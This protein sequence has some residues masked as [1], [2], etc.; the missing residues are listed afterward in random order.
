MEKKKKK[1]VKLIPN[2][3]MYMLARIGAGAV[4][5]FLYKRKFMRNEIKNIKGP[6]IILA[7]HESALDFVNLINATRAK[8]NFVVSNS[9]YNTLPIREAMR[10]AGVIPK[11]QFQTNMHDIGRMREVIRNNGILVMYPAGLMC[12]D[13]IS[14][15]IPEPTYRFVQWLAADVYIARSYGTYFCKPKWA[16]KTRPGRTYI[17]IYKLC[18]KD[19]LV[20]MSADDFRLMCESA[21]LF[22][23]YREQEELLVKYKGGDNL[24]GLENILYVCPCCRS[25][26]KIVTEGNT[27]RCV[28]CGYEEYSDE[29]GFLHKRSGCGAEMRYVSDWNGFAVTVMSEKINTGAFQGLYSKAKIY[30]IDY[31]KKK[32]VESGEGE[33]TLK[34][35]ALRLVGVVKGEPVDITTPASHFPSLP[36]KPGVNIDF[37]HGGEIYRLELEDGRLCMEFINAIK[38][39]YQMSIPVERARESERHDEALSVNV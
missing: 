38:Y 19:E 11:N 26:H 7:N 35:A 18:N 31:K 36:F 24:E 22:D 8:M 2:K 6:A 5:K 9:F 34:D 32:Y 17:D 1:K 33:L 10:G 4:S 30:T 27:I 16:K 15:P 28:E 20:S 23:A 29:Y 3:F 13:G 14:T 25:E 21:L 39:Y 37:Q 12:E